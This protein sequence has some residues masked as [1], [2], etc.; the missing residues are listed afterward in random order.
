MLFSVIE[1]GIAPLCF[2]TGKI[3]PL[4]RSSVWQ[5]EYSNDVTQCSINEQRIPFYVLNV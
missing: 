3:S 4:L 5:F 2:Q 1:H